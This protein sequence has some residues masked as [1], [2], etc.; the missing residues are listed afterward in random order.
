MGVWVFL[1]ET[2]IELAVGAAAE[3]DIKTALGVGPHHASLFPKGVVEDNREGRVGSKRA[4]DVERNQPVQ[5]K[6]ESSR[7][8]SLALHWLEVI[9]PNPDEHDRGRE[10]NSDAQHV[11]SD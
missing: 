7:T 5:G 11:Q 9:R 10:L 6:I 1:N 4:Q 2:L 3:H 8:V